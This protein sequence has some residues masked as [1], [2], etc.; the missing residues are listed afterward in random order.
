MSRRNNIH[1]RLYAKL[2]SR[3]DPLPFLLLSADKSLCRNTKFV[4]ID[5]EKLIITKKTAI[6]K[7]NEITDL[8][9]DIEFLPD[10]NAVQVRSKQYIALGC[11]LKNLK[12]LGDALKSDILPS[13]CSILCT[14]EVSL[15]Y[16]DVKFADAVIGFASKLSNG[17]EKKYMATVPALT[18]TLK[19]YSFAS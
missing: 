12:K 6:Q 16:M 3:S 15:T 17:K 4:D 13:E 10:E 8:L 19:M 18:D 11:D 1:R 2:R 14:A 7:T 9:E 5:Y